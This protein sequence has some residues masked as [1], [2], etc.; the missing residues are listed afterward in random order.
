MSYLAADLARDVAHACNKARPGMTPEEIQTV[1]HEL[2][3]KIGEALEPPVEP[4]PEAH[5]EGHNFRYDD[6]LK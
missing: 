3:D 6:K 5:V 4:P 2:S 1:L